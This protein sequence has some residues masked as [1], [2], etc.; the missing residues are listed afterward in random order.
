VRKQRTCKQTRRRR[1]RRTRP[2]NHPESQSQ[3][4]K[5]PKRNLPSRET[6]TL[7]EIK[8]PPTGPRAAPGELRGTSCTKHHR[9][10]SRGLNNHFDAMPRQEVGRRTSE[11]GTACLPDTNHPLNQGTTRQ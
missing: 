1:T 5:A 3:L 10:P 2:S 8:Q 9:S 7:R 11:Q 6:T 4:G